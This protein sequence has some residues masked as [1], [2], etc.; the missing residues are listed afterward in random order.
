ME[1]T[2]IKDDHNV[3]QGHQDMF[4]DEFHPANMNNPDDEIGI[5]EGE[6]EG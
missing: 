4:N 2:P 5:S 1:E 6:N 3:H